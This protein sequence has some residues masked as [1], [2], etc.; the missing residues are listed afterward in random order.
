MAS[1]FRGKWT[2]YSPN[3]KKYIGYQGSEIL[4]CMR[5][6][7]GKETIVV[8]VLRANNELCFFLQNG[9]YVGP[10]PETF[11][12]VDQRGHAGVFAFPGHDYANLPAS[13]TSKIHSTIDNTYMLDVV[14]Y[15]FA[16]KSESA[17]RLFTITQHTPTLEQIQAST[18]GDGLDL[19]GVDLTGG[20]L[21]SVS[22]VGTDFSHSDISNAKLTSCTLTKALL[23]NCTMSQT[24]LSGSNLSGA[25]LNELDLTNVVIGTSL[26]QFCT[27]PTVAPS[28]TDP[29]TTFFKSK[30]KQSLLGLQ[31]S[32]LDL[33]EA[34]LKIEA[35]LN[36]KDQ[37]ISAMHSI[38]TGL[39]QNDLS[40]VAFQSAKFDY[41]V[42]DHVDLTGS[43][44]TGAS[45]KYASMHETVLSDATLK[46][47]D[48]TGAQLGS[49][50]QLFTLPTGFET[51]LNTGPVNAETRD[52]FSHNG[53]TLSAA[54]TLSTQALGRVWLLNDTD[55]NVTYTIRLDG[56]E[57]KV[58]TVYKQGGA[59]SLVNAYM[60]DAI[61]AQANLY[62][63][64]ATGAQ[65]YGSKAS[66]TDAILEKVEFNNANLS[67]VNFTKAQL[68]GANL[69]N[70][71]LFNA[72]FN[73]A[74]LSPSADG[75]AA[76]LSN[77]NLQ[78][79]DFTDAQLYGA[80]LANAAVAIN[81]STKAVQK[82]GGVYLFSLPGKTDTATLAQYVAELTAA[83]KTF[84]LP[85]TVDTTTLD[86]YK[87]ALKANNIAPLKTAFLKQKPPIVLTQAAAI[88]TIEVDSVWQI[89]D[90]TH[91]YT[92]WIDIDPEV[93]DPDKDPYGGNRLFIA[94]SLIVTQAGFKESHM[95]LRWQATVTVDSA[96]Q[97][98]LIDNDS[99][100]P[101]NPSTGYMRFIVTLKD[102]A[103]EVYGSAL[104]ILRL[105]DHQQEEFD[106]ETCQV[107]KLSQNN[108]S[109]D[110]VCPNGHPLVVNQSKS[111]KTWDNLWLRAAALPKPPV[112]VP[113]DFR[114]CDATPK[115]KKK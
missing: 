28:P 47:A 18:N 33:R 59:A 39:N 79:A 10:G 48:L 105:G 82:Q 14:P 42:L 67:T 110:T 40:G 58:L 83:A 36:C 93:D 2:V 6:G 107:T 104:R 45:L 29:R 111:G 106:T 30:L 25:N 63:V 19:A 87:A 49:L 60:P 15:V 61:L 52:Q 22:L 1:T 80:N 64:I 94:P 75:V 21:N 70:S 37:H 92:L 44:L 99:E 77:T 76:N 91:S 32:K 88:T 16:E 24:D 96:N 43:D 53:I 11:G 90:G 8:F 71:Q 54:A 89:V 13:F 38:L 26:P 73:N 103:L 95:T 27:N 51:H 12:F 35:E 115:K 98:W 69:S 65:F 34:T 81:V 109:E 17:A 86:N 23:N 108:M 78:G 9:K 114:F 72:K 5:Q 100:N 97:Q 112:C 50:S 74:N 7:P 20:E 68:R 84:M 55:H 3:N 101:K 46:G 31:W 85:Y 62:A 56:D 41:A 66:V 57:T 4:L 102:S 113:T